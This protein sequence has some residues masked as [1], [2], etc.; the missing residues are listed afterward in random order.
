MTV[1]ESLYQLERTFIKFHVE[2]TGDT[3]PGYVWWDRIKDCQK[4]SDKE[5]TYVPMSDSQTLKIMRSWV[6]EQKQTR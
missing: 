6:K 4:W 5:R 2:T 3:D 1:L